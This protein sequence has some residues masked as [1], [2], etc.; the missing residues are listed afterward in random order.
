MSLAKKLCFVLVAVSMITA[1]PA[2]ASS[3]KPGE[4]S[5]G[6]PQTRCLLEETI[7]LS[8]IPRP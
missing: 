8:F 3:D 6:G 4:G 7:V 1:A 2:F 5:A